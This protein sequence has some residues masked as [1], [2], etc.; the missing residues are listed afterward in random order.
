MGTKQRL[1]WRKSWLGGWQE[2]AA[3]SVQDDMAR[4]RPW[5]WRRLGQNWL[6]SGAEWLVQE[7][8]GYR[9]EQFWETLG[10]LIWVG[11]I[12]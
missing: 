7:G 4:Q 3:E 12:M 1:N 9:R 5:T 8:G 2:A 10:L 11:V 6:G